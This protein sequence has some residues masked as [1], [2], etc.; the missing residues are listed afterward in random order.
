VAVSVEDECNGGDK[1][2]HDQLVGIG[3]EEF[4]ESE[5]GEEGSSHE[6]RAEDVCVE[7]GFTKK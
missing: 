2:D 5:E 6:E 1:E 3:A 7:S 4:V